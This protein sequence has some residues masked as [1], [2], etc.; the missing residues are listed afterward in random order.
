MKILIICN[1]PIDLEVFRG[2]LIRE[3]VKQGNMVYAIVSKS[4][5]KKEIDAEN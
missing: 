2:M 3:L 1:C 5:E 4:D